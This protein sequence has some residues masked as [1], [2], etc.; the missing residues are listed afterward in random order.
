MPE[1]SESGHILMV[2]RLELGH[3]LRIPKLE[4]T[5]AEKKTHYAYIAKKTFSLEHGIPGQTG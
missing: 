5:S 1:R 2:K 4:K 3:I